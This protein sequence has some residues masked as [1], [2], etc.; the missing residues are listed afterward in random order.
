MDVFGGVESVATTGALLAAIWQLRQGL[1]DGRARDDDRRTERALALYEDVVAESATYEAFHRLSVLLR[2]RGSADFG[3]TTWHVLSDADLSSGGYLDPAEVDSAQA[4]A[5]LYAV[6]WFFERC[7]ASLDRGLVDHEVLMSTLGFHFWWW[8]QLL[9]RLVGPKATQAVHGLA[10][11]AERWAT[12]N[13]ALTDWRARC[14]TDFAGGPGRS[15]VHG[16][17]TE[18]RRDDRSAVTP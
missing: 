14:A 1:R 16:R 2:R 11:D 10:A 5:D 9:A 13:G 3:T 12:A 18:V 7:E 17:S 8:G 6:M 4:F 15:L